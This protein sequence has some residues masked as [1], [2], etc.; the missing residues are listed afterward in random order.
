MQQQQFENPPPLYSATSQPPQSY[1]GMLYPA[2]T[3]SY[4]SGPLPMQSPYSMSNAPNSQQPYLMQSG[5]MPM[6]QQAQTQ[7]YGQPYHPYSLSQAHPQQ[8]PPQIPQ[9]QQQQQQV[10]INMMANMYSQS[11]AFQPPSLPPPPPPPIP[12][13]F[14]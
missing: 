5:S 7:L 12:P 2:P 3:T 13:R 8:Q 9:Q 14:P 1:Y 4:L 6:P 10:D 11:A